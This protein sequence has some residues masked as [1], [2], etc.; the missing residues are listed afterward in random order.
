MADN[1]N[2]HSEQIIGLTDLMVQ[3]LQ[4]TIDADRS[5]AD[6]YFRIL[7]EN[8]FRVG[9]DGKSTELQM[10]D[11][12]IRNS[13]GQSQIISVPKM[14][15]MPIPML[16]I[17]EASFELEGKMCLNKTEENTVSSETDEASKPIDASR[18]QRSISPSALTKTSSGGRQ[19]LPQGKHTM[20]ERLER[21]SLISVQ[22]Q[23]NQGM[24]ET[25]TSTEN[26]QST[27]N[28]KITMKLTQSDM[29]SGL[30]SLLQV[31]TNNIQVKNE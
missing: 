29:P 16:H 30:V 1:L 2:E 4:A 31:M 23:P 27:T 3:T 11:V 18:L 26:T 10:V 6:E 28:L 8:S 17:S 15:L 24:E 12:R 22:L 7:E 9:D 19:V 5:T 14:V 20:I 13:N 21:Q 25:G